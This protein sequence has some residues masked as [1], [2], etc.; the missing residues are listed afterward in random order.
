MPQYDLDE[1]TRKI[2]LRRDVKQAAKPLAKGMKKI[3]LGYVLRITSEEKPSDNDD[4]VLDVFD[5]SPDNTNMK[6]KF[7]SDKEIKEIQ[8]R[9]RAEAWREA[10][11]A[12]LSARSGIPVAELEAKWDSGNFDGSEAK[13]LREQWKRTVERYAKKCNVDP[14]DLK[15]KVVSKEEFKKK[16]G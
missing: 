2:I 1:R 14:K 16:F 8:A 6:G 9:A 5:E 11:L 4:L 3:V 13:A 15:G 12:G 10:T 7:Y